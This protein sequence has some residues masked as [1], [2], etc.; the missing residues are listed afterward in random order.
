M[1]RR[2]YHCYWLYRSAWII[3]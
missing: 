1:S 2:S 3:V